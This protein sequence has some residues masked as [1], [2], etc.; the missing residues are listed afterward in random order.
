L[1]IIYRVNHFN[2]HS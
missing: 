2:K 1:T